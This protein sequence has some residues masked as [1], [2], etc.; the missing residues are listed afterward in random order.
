MVFYSWLSKHCNFTEGGICVQ[1]DDI[2]HESLFSCTPQLSPSRI[3]STLSRL[4]TASSFLNLHPSGPPSPRYPQHDTACHSLPLLVKQTS[5]HALVSLP[6]KAPQPLL[7]EPW[8]CSVPSTEWALNY[9]LLSP[10]WAFVIADSAADLKNKTCF[11][12]H[13]K[14]FF[15]NGQ[16]DIK[17][18]IS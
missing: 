15:L 10:P 13:D 4:N 17:F 6:Q 14:L 2:L 16:K 5:A 18:V 12:W 1:S 9:L 11:L 7:H 8:G 3:V